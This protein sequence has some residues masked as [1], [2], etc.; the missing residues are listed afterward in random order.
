VSHPRTPFIEYQL[1]LRPPRTPHAARGFHRH[2]SEADGAV[3]REPSIRRP[4]I[5]RSGTGRV[6]QLPRLGESG[7]GTT[8][9]TAILISIVLVVLIILLFVGFK[10]VKPESLRLKVWNCLEFEMRGQEG[11]E[12]PKRAIKRS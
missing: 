3:R 5:Y 2:G 10:W 11:P 12:P 1:P 7:R 9:G 6:V 4:I 8:L